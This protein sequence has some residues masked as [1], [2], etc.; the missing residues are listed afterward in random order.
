MEPDHPVEN[1]ANTEKENDTI[2]ISKQKLH[3]RMVVGLLLVFLLSA[4]SGLLV[5]RYT[6]AVQKAQVEQ[7]ETEQADNA[8]AAIREVLEEENSARSEYYTH[9]KQSADL[10]Q[11]LLLPFVN[12][13]DRY[14]GP[15]HLQDG[16][17]IRMENGTVQWPSGFSSDKMPIPDDFP[18]GESDWFDTV[19]ET[20]EGAK[21]AVIVWR[22]ICTDTYYL[23]WTYEED[24]K[25]YIDA[26]I[27]RDAHL[28]AI[29]DVSSSWFIVLDD[30]KD[31]SPVYNMMEFSNEVIQGAKASAAQGLGSYND[32][33]RD[34]HTLMVP[35]G[36]TQKTALFLFPQ[37]EVYDG[38]ESEALIISM[39]I[40]L[41][42]MVTYVWLIATK[43]MVYYHILTKP[44]V[45][46]YNPRTMRR[47]TAAAGAFCMILLSLASVFVQKAGRMYR[48]VKDSAWKL[49][50]Y[51]D[52]LVQMK[53]NEKNAA[54]EEQ[55][56]I[57]YYA[58]KMA[59]LLEAYPDR[60]GNAL[61]SALSDDI[62]AEYIM[63]FD[64][65][66]NET[67]CSTD[68]TRFT[69]GEKE[70][71]PLYTFRRINKG[72]EYVVK[73]PGPDMILSKETSLV[74]WRMRLPEEAGY[75]VLL[76]SM[77]HE[78][79]DPADPEKDKSR[80]MSAAVISSSMM[81]SLNSDK[82]MV[83]TCALP[84]YN[85]TS[86]EASGLTENLLKESDLCQFTLFDFP[87]TGA[88]R[89]ID[90]KLC[91]YGYGDW[92]GRE[93]AVSFAIL[94][95]V[96]GL[97]SFAI[98][99]AWLLGNYTQETFEKLAVV[100]AEAVRGSN[101]EIITADGR[102]KRTRDPSRRNEISLDAWKNLLPENKTKIILQLILFCYLAAVIYSVWTA[103]GLRNTF[104][105][106]LIGN[107]W[108][109]GLNLIAIAANLLII[110]SV[111]LGLLLLRILIRL[112]CTWLDTKGETVVRLLFNLL[113]YIALFTTLF[114]CFSNFGVD[115][116][117][118]LTT[119]GLLSLAVSIGAKDL[120]SDI[121][122]G[123]TIV[124]EGDYQVGDIVEI[125]G[126]RGR[127]QEIGVRS[128][129]IMGLGDNIKTINNRD[130]RNVI[131]TTRFNSWYALTLNIASTYDIGKLEEILERELPNIRSRMK[132]VISGP[133]Y[134]GVE[135]IGKDS[136]KIT[137]LTECK[138]ENLRWV[139]RQ[140]NR[141]IRILFDQ[142]GIPII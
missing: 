28:K 20:S 18:N 13:E 76:I 53:E 131:N 112:V 70:S 94:C 116:S 84:M 136:F 49:E 35:L 37:D 50:L 123:I 130:V 113:E 1:T 129:K 54:V 77:D 128:T 114:Y 86:L 11:D 12:D 58:K 139:Q 115:T 105:T 57:L 64:E 24:E 43:R 60:V 59:V 99:A 107:T 110:A 71:D 46:R 87:Y 120:V 26:N 17:V 63:L 29:E 25:A 44:Q 79:T 14:E 32:G 135:S 22:Q 66:G 92:I 106:Y 85:N 9:L 119:M 138:E 30:T 38:A 19:I 52:A 134:R 75:G 40:F 103:R 126:Y 65:N 74:G 98:L 73:E 104:V 82:T 124:L 10:S 121:I 67:L 47:R 137:I 95:T 81:A 15:L 111:M 93:S 80:L 122:A 125:D 5:K 7:N 68:F 42:L 2:F 78:N 34:Y 23:E 51:E 101:V 97:G 4:V 61:L 31:G 118:L 36:D 69:L 56:W 140:V 45:I 142:E 16:I 55:E 6:V 39:L 117:A 27:L 102:I 72:L 8:A 109:K 62:G 83:E 90:G 108:E 48:N 100:G 141:E 88:S 3:I 41:I 21:E 89:V 96:L 127:V 133:V 91:F 33:Y 132:K